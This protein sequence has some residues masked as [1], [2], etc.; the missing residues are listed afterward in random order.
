MKY[1]IIKSS[2]LGKEGSIVEYDEKK[3]KWMCEGNIIEKKYLEDTE[4]FEKMKEGRW[5]ANK[6]NKYWYVCRNGT[7][8]WNIEDGSIV[9][10]FLHKTH[11]YFETIEEAWNKLD[12]INHIYKFPMPE[13]RDDYFWLDMDDKFETGGYFDGTISDKTDYHSGSIMHKD[14]TEEDRAERIRLLKLVYGNN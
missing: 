5:R 8:D 13:I 9:D 12:L 6:N 11:N 2:P 7:A 3:R 14:T 4:Y 10:I 1:K